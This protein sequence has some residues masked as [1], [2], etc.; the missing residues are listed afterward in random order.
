MR[1]RT[2]DLDRFGCRGFNKKQHFF[3]NEQQFNPTPA[4]KN[5][6]T[7]YLF[8]IDTYFMT[9]QGLLLD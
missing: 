3:L 5:P 7:L 1:G 6:K 4:E 2:T 9:S 8:K